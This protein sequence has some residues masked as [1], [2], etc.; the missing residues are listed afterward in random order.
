MNINTLRAGLKGLAGSVPY[1]GTLLTADV[2]SVRGGAA[3]LALAVL[4]QLCCY[5]LPKECRTYNETT[6][7]L[8]RE[9]DGRIASFEELEAEEP[10]N[11]IMGEGLI[12]LVNE[13]HALASE[14]MPEGVRI[15]GVPPYCGSAVY[16][17]VVAYTVPRGRDGGQS[18]VYVTGLVTFAPRPNRFFPWYIVNHEVGHL[19]RTGEGNEVVAELN[20]IDQI[21]AA[22][23]LLSNEDD[24]FERTLLWTYFTDPYILSKDYLIPEYANEDNYINESIFIFTN[25]SETNGDIQRLREKIDQLEQ[26]GELGYAI[27]DS[28]QRFQQ[29]YGLLQPDIESYNRNFWAREAD[30]HLVARRYIFDKLK[31]SFGL[32]VAQ[33]YFAVTSFF[34][35]ERGGVSEEDSYYSRIAQG[36]DGFSCKV[37]ER[38]SSGRQPCGDVQECVEIGAAYRANINLDLCCLKLDKDEFSKWLIETTGTTYRPPEK[39][40]LHLSNIDTNWPERADFL[41]INSKTQIGLEERCR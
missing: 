31:R 38:R 25:L 19:Q 22:Y 14:G 41:S 33:N 8:N 32:G 13:T 11:G 37:V 27:E 39:R 16:G 36:L 4:P 2:R 1:L 35:N 9:T 7:T 3:V 23:G 6:I 28:V 24:N 40:Q 30:T 29:K 15:T 34:P 18:G 21:I 17:N 5:D 20:Y 10:L 26:R 12:D